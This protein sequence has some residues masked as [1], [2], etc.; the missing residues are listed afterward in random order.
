MTNKSTRRFSQRPSYHEAE[1]ASTAHETNSSFEAN[2]EPLVSFHNL[3]WQVSSQRNG[4]ADVWGERTTDSD[5]N[6]S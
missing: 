3:G 4:A 2:I 1:S 5:R 6:Q